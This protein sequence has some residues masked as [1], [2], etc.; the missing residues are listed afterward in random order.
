[1]G[2]RIAAFTPDRKL[3]EGFGNYGSNMESISKRRG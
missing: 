3:R 1:M 2:L